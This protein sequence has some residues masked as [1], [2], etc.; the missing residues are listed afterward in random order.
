MA[1][2]LTH[3]AERLIAALP[4]DPD[5]ALAL[6]LDATTP[7][8]LV[9]AVLTRFIAQGHEDAWHAFETAC[10][11]VATQVALGLLEP[12]QDW[13]GETRSRVLAALLAHREAVVRSAVVRAITSSHQGRTLPLLLRASRDPIPAIARRGKTALLQLVTADAT[14]LVQLPRATALGVLSCMEPAALLPLLAPRGGEVLRELAATALGAHAQAQVR[15]ELLAAGIAGGEGVARAAL[16]SLRAHGGTDEAPFV[17]L[18]D[19]GPRGIRTECLEALGMTCGERGTAV[20]LDACVAAIPEQRIAALAALSKRGCVEAIARLE[21]ALRDEESTVRDHALEALLL[22][23]GSDAILLRL[24][25][26]GPETQRLPALTE[27]AR[28]GLGSTLLEGAAS[29]L[30]RFGATLTDVTRTRELDGVVAVAR[31]LARLQHPEALAG[32]RAL[33]TSVIRR[34]RREAG[35]GL[36]QYSIAARRDSLAALVG[37][38]DRDLLQVVAR[39]LVEAKDSAA[40]VP[41]LRLTLECRGRVVV[42]AHEA[43]QSDPRHNELDALLGALHSEF[44]AAK[45]AAA[46]RLAALGDEGAVAGLLAV[47]NET[48]VE[49][50]LAALEALT[51]FTPTHDEVRARMLDALSFGDLSV[52]QTACE[53]LGLARCVEAVPA[54]IVVL[55]SNFLRPRA[56]EA[57]RRIGD[58]RGF[59]AMRRLERR[60][61]LRAEQKALARKLVRKR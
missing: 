27:A 42:W 22:H 16:Q 51:A 56:V 61:A 4:Q 5:E 14:L 57:L 34:L 18:W 40:L 41:L 7:A 28:R 29:D 36:M 58:R 11:Q 30:L 37:T 49:V 60:T 44:A 6:A 31:H 45:R 25:L 21:E 13:N 33:G 9:D 47:S 48:E 35:D 23:S 10:P 1:K 59:I 8:V 2:V 54:L 12:R 53:A 39:G 17:Q 19:M 55:G 26:E 46:H 20:L 38:H 3:A 50:Q 32:L 43:L 15:A 24:A 52:R